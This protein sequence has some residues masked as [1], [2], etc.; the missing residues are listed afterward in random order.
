MT[1][2]LNRGPQYFVLPLQGD[3]AILT[4][5]LER[6]LV[7][8]SSWLEHGETFVAGVDDEF[9]AAR[10]WIEKCGLTNL[11]I[12]L[13]RDSWHI[14]AQTIEA[15]SGALGGLKIADGSG[16]LKMV[17]RRKSAEEITYI[18]KAGVL[19]AKGM[20]AAVAAAQPGVLDSEVAATAQNAMMAAGSEWL[21]TE[22]Y[23]TTGRRSGIPHSTH[24][25]VTINPGDPVWLEMS[26]VYERYNCPL[27]RTLFIGDPPDGAVKLG[28]AAMAALDVVLATCKPGVIAEDVAAAASKELPL[29]DPEILFHHWYG[30]SVG[31]GFP[32]SWADDPRARLVKGNTFPLESGM[33][34]H[35]T[36]SLRRNA[37]YGVC[38]SETIHI[39]DTGCEVLGSFPRKFFYK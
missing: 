39:T 2:S 3:A 19:T 16:V 23:V 9:K 21:C 4:A 7:L 13:E 10:R 5:E 37:Q 6:P 38:V 27:M 36:M 25:R 11:R 12:G 31:L 29:D 1:G 26:G 30:Y 32:P 8:Y 24:H 17:M 15:L 28:K 35:S 33:V 14:S 22:P 18:R 20:E 34:F